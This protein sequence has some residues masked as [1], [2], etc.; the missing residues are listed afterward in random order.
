MQIAMDIN[1][2]RGGLAQPLLALRG[3]TKHFPLKGGL[4]GRTVATV[5]AVDDVSFDVMKGETLGIV[6]ESGCG[7]LTT[8]RLFSFWVWMPAAWCSMA[9]GG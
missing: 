5:R 2:D 3:L 1:P 8:A 4:L 7:K 9:S 6:G